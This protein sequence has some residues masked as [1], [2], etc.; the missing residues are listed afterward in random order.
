VS[1]GVLYYALGGGHGHVLRG[2]AVL[3]RLGH[4]TLLG[5]ARL[6]SWAA[7]LGVTYVSPSAA[8]LHAWPAPGLLVVDVFPRGV[9]GELTPLLQ[10]TAVAWLIAR[11]VREHYYLHP[12]VR[13]AL[14]RCYERV[15]W[16]EAPPPGLAALGTNSIRLPP[17]LLAA[18]G[19]ERAQARRHLDVALEAPLILGLGSGEAERQHRLCRL[20]GNIA[21]R[22]GAALRFVSTELASAGPVVSI[23]PAA[24]WLPAADVVVT[25]AGYHAA[26]ETARAGVP[27]VF[28]PQARA[29]D[30]QRWRAGERVTHATA[31]CAVAGDPPAL[32]AAI[33]RLLR[34]GRRSPAR[35]GDGAAAL[36]RL[37][38]RRVELGI[39][40]QEEIAALA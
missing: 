35:V 38:E 37:I 20:L 24:A 13:A 21:A 25:A 39:L 28:V 22:H 33:A 36:A 3:S 4:G 15:A 2:L 27:T 12:P 11:R 14:E 32:E 26:Y 10:R 5:P 31:A 19:L 8:E 9:V 23:F 29:Y 16:C 7:A 30:D 17:I 34:D 6:A 1:A 40:P 18:P